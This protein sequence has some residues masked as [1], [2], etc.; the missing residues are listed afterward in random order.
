[1]SKNVNP[2]EL[3]GLEELSPMASAEIRGGAD[4]KQ[5]QKQEVDVE[6]EGDI[7]L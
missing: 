6:I 7:D 2:K 1:M 4:K 3:L 5:E